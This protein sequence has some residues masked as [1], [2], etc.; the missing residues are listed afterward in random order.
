VTVYARGW[1]ADRQTDRRQQQQSSCEATKCSVYVVWRR[2]VSGN[3][4]SWLVSRCQTL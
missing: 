2:S 1:V 4:F 3:G